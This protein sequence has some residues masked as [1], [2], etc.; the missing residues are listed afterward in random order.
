MEIGAGVP[1]LCCVVR[2][3]VHGVMFS[4]S[5]SVFVFGSSFV[6][7][8]FILVSGFWVLVSGNARYLSFGVWARGTAAMAVV[9]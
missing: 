8:F 6:I 7:G 4:V 5:V 2:R 9:R 3:I 1:V